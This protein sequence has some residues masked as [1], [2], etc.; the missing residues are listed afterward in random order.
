MIQGSFDSKKIDF[1][2]FDKG[3]TIAYQKK[4]ADRGIPR[5]QK[6]M[7]LLGYKGDPEHYR[8]LFIDRTKKYKDWSFENCYE[9]TVED[10]CTKWLFFDAPLKE[11]LIKYADTLVR[12]NAQIK[13]DRV[14]YPEASPVIKE[15]KKRGYR[16]GLISNTVSSTLLPEELKAVDIWDDMEV[17]IL[18]S[19]VRIKKPNPEIFRMG[20]EKAGIAPEKCVYIGDQPNRDVE[21]PR[22]SGFAGVILLKTEAYDPEKDKGPLRAPDAVV[23]TLTEL[24]DIFPPRK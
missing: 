1:I 22:K 8:K 9:D 4:T 19:D 6:I 13:G 2:F 24:L 7:E 17:A 14:M 23:D 5:V 12:H 3:G 21:G 15:L 10:M 11:N 18:S 20:C 16:V